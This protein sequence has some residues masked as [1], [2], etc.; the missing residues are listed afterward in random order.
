MDTED[1]TDLTPGLNTNLFASTHKNFDVIYNAL[2]SNYGELKDSHVDEDR[3]KFGEN[4]KAM[5]GEMHKDSTT[6]VKR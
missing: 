1:R 4:M 3:Q 2:Q 6:D 5:G